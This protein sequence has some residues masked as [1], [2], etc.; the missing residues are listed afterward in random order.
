MLGAIQRGRGE[1]GS[2]NERAA[3]AAY[4]ELGMQPLRLEN[5]R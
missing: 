4:A 3:A 1:D 5:S 2:A